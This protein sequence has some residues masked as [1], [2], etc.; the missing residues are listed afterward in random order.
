MKPILTLLAIL[1]VAACSPKNPSEFDSVSRVASGKPV[2]VMLTS[3]STTLLANGK[4]QTRLRIAITDSLSREI[5]SA[6]DSIRMYVE[7]D[8]KV[9]DSD[10]K[11]LVLRTDISGKPYAACRLA[12]GTCQL[13]FIAGNTPG[14][15]K[16]EARS[17]K[18]WP[19][20]HEIHTLPASFVMMKPAPD[21]A[22]PGT[23]PIDR[24]WRALI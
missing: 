24:M 18:L 8:G 10:G 19:G 23:K 9:M 20:S 12:N 11:D 21:Q 5:T 13:I 22:P 14:K 6:T 7:G 3:Y 1:L 4:D 17:G 16:V 15:V 2:S